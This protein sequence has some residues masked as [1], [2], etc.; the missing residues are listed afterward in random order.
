[1]LRLL[2]L[3][4]GLGVLP[5]AIHRVADQSLCRRRVGIVR[6]RR[7]VGAERLLH[8]IPSLCLGRAAALLDQRLLRNIG[9]RERGHEPIDDHEER[10]LRAAIALVPDEGRVEGNYRVATGLLGEFLI[11]VAVGE[12]RLR[13]LGTRACVVARSEQRFAEIAID[14]LRAIAL[15]EVG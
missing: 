1:M 11:A 9:L 15:R 7:R 3:R 4:L 2:P 5:A 13:E 6:I 8:R 14:D 10:V 12:R